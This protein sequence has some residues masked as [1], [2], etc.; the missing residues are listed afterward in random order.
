[1]VSRPQCTTVRS[2][3]FARPFEPGRLTTFR[4][5]THRT[6]AEEYWLP[7]MQETVTKG[8]ARLTRGKSKVFGLFDMSGPIRTATAQVGEGMDNIKLLYQYGA[9]MACGSDATKCLITPAS[10]DLGLAMPDFLINGE[11]QPGERLFTGADALWMA[12]LHSARA[13]GLEDRVD[14]RLAIN[15]CGLKLEVVKGVV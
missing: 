2:H 1:V 14:G 6:F 4:E 3:P 13:M 9:C 7:E 11:L 8:V 5:K 12:T 15:D 10:I